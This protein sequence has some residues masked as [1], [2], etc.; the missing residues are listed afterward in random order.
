M[1]DE[2]KELQLYTFDASKTRRFPKDG[3]MLRLNTGGKGNA[4]NSF[5]CVPHAMEIVA[6]QALYHDGA[7][8]ERA[9]E[10]VDVAVAALCDWC[11]F[12]GRTACAPSIPGLKDCH[13]WM[14]RYIAAYCKVLAPTASKEE[15]DSEWK[16]RKTRYE[17]ELFAG[18]GLSGK[19]AVDYQLVVAR[20]LR[21]G[22]L[23]TYCMVGKITPDEVCTTT[24]RKKD[25]SFR[26]LR[27][28]KSKDVILMTATCLMSLRQVGQVPRT[29]FV[30]VNLQL[31]AR[32]LG[33]RKDSGLSD[34]DTWLYEGE[35][36]FLHLKEKSGVQQ[37]QINQPWLDDGQWQLIDITDGDEPL[38]R[39]CREHEGEGFSCY[40]DADY[41]NPAFESSAS[42]FRSLLRQACDDL[43]H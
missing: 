5:A 35:E 6:R 16:T 1:L 42:P 41:T 17:K 9:S 25:G 14:K 10:R 18:S 24:T 31:L 29:G 28:E 27:S 7:S 3:T 30:P 26:K 38:R 4:R 37:Y 12:A 40:M 20:A 15:L 39:F 34:M 2:R 36:L 8:F 13:R 23:R 22:P 11:G 21:R 19:D 43:I 33:E 32:W